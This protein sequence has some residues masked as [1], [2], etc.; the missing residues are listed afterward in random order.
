MLA[1]SKVPSIH[2]ADPQMQL[3][4]EQ[5]K[6]NTIV[7]SSASV[8]RRQS[9]APTKPVVFR[10]VVGSVKKVVKTVLHVY[11]LSASCGSENRNASAVHLEPQSLV[12]LSS[13]PLPNDGEVVEQH[14]SGGHVHHRHPHR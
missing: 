2:G 9:F 5:E 12:V 10:P 4:P 6:S 3:E 13:L 11:K 1:E 14:A 8:G 7:C